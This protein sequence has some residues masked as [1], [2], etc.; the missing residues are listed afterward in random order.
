MAILGAW[1]CRGGDVGSPTRCARHGVLTPWRDWMMHGD[2]TPPTQ[3]GLP[4]DGELS[5]GRDE[6]PALPFLARTPGEERAS[7]LRAA[8]GVAFTH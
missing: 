7:G 3:Y 8:D 1:L 2:L 5:T 6:I 4:M